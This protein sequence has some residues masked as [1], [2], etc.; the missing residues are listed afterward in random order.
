MSVD[1]VDDVSDAVQ[2]ALAV[3][4]R[5][6]A[7]DLLVRSSNPRDALLRLTRTKAKSVR[8]WIPS[9][10]VEVL[11]AEA[12][13]VLVRLLDDQDP[14]TRVLAL[15]A[16]EEVD[17]ARLSKEVGRLIRRLDSGDVSEVLATAWFL[18]RIPGA[19]AADAI[20]L[21]RDSAASPHWL[22]YALDSV[23]LFVTDPNELVARLRAHDHLRTQ[24]L[25]Y[26]ASLLGT[27]EAFAALGDCAA[28]AEDEKCRNICKNLLEETRA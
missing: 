9:L 17:P 2:R 3:E 7:A 18:A 1:S 12:G 28:T 20:K 24:W 13:P 15:G 25:A 6:A 10:A 26:G 4:D 21:A 11:G 19:N 5:S 16:L 23:L 14:D 27:E 22:H 8:A